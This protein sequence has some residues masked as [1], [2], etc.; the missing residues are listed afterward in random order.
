MTLTSTL[1]LA[2]GVTV[3]V[4]AVER[5]RGICGVQLTANKSD[6][7]P[8]V[9]AMWL[10]LIM[11]ELYHKYGGMALPKPT[12]CTLLASINVLVGHASIPRTPC[13]ANSR[14]LAGLAQMGVGMTDP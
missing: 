3:G 6:S 8:I 11:A 4:T 9:L 14:R 10:R 1:A 13:P 12:F 7:N 2:S 5:R